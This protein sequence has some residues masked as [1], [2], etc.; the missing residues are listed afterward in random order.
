VY[1]VV[2]DG[3]KRG[4]LSEERVSGRSF[5]IGQLLVKLSEKR[6]QSYTFSFPRPRLY[7]MSTALVLQWYNGLNG[8]TPRVHTSVIKK[9]TL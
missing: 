6:S 5:R 1:G 8:V 3:C 7:W 9:T 2:G 4:K